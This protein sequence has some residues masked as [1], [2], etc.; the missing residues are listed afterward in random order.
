MIEVNVLAIIKFDQPLLK[1]SL[2]HACEVQYVLGCEN[3]NAYRVVTSNPYF[4]LGE[5][6]LRR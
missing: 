6:S 2:V 3:R 5:V 4:L 1:S